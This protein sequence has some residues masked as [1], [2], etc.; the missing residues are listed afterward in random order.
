[1]ETK[2]FGEWCGGDH[3]PHAKRSGLLPCTACEWPCRCATNERN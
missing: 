2:K 3:K 1:V